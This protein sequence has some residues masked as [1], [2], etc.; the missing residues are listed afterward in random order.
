MNPY[1]VLGLSED[2]VLSE[3]KASYRKLAKIHHPD[4][5]TGSA[6]K[7]RELN[8]AYQSLLSVVNDAP[9]PKRKKKKEPVPKQPAPKHGEVYYRILDSKSLDEHVEFFDDKFSPRT[10]IKFMRGQHEFT[11]FFLEERKFPFTIQIENLKI[12]FKQQQRD[13]FPI[14]R[15]KK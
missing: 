1:L 9:P 15:P 2:A 14:R 7:F 3:V 8:A 10:R 6:D 11:I 5:A 13:S 12:T 4:F